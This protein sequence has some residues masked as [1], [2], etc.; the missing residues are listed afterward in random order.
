MNEILPR[1]LYSSL[2]F[3]LFLFYHIV[4]PSLDPLTAE[5]ND[6]AKA[7]WEAIL[8]DDTPAYLARKA[9][10]A[11]SQKEEREKS[12]ALTSEPLQSCKE[13][14]TAL[15]YE[16]LFDVH[17]Y[18][19]ALFADPETQGKFLIAL[20]SFIFTAFDNPRAYMAKLK[21]G[22]ITHQHTPLFKSNPGPYLTLTV[23]LSLLPVSW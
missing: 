11:D 1:F 6:L 23:T 20:F 3:H 22:L 9:A 4:E 7:S 17:P 12:G 13:W 16:R 5:E 21:V 14:F 8:K 18:A 2:L 19:K 15:F 10:L